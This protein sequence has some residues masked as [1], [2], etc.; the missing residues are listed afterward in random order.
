MTFGRPVFTLITLVLM[1]IIVVTSI[2][3]PIL[4]LLAT[5]AFLAIWS[6]R[7]TLTLIAEAEARRAEAAEKAAGANVRPNTDKGRGGQI[8]PR[9]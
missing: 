9:E 3:L 8:R 7:A 4:L 6:F 2:W 5:F 1:A